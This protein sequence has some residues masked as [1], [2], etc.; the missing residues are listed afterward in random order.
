MR[1]DFEP[2]RICCYISI[3]VTRK[4]DVRPGKTW[5]IKG[6]SFSVT[7][8]EINF[9]PPLGSRRKCNGSV[10]TNVFGPFRTYTKQEKQ[11]K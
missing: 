7:R 6:D 4:W 1:A 8:T 10:W 2:K 5:R 9:R 3:A 11:E